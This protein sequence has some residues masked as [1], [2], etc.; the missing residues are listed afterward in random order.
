[1][2]ALSPLRVLALTAHPDNSIARIRLGIPL[3][4]LARQRTIHW[5]MRSVKQ[6]RLRDVLAAQVVIIQREATPVALQWA[7]LARAMGRPLVYEIDD[8]LT[9][10]EP[11]L[12]HHATLLAHV[13]RVL[14]M[15]ALADRISVSTARLQAALPTYVQHK[16]QLTPNYSQPSNVPTTY[17]TE[18]SEA[19]PI[20]LVLASSDAMSLNAVVAGIA[21]WQGRHA[22]P[23]KIV[24][25]G[26]MAKELSDRLAHVEPHHTLSLPA[27]ER[28]MCGLTNPIGL[29]PLDSSPFNACKSAVKFFHY[30]TWGMPVIASNV[31]PYADVILDGCHGLL[32]DANA[33]AWCQAIDHLAS[34]TSRRRTMVAAAQALIAD[35]HSLALTTLAW[36]QLLNDI[37]PDSLPELGWARW[38]WVPRHDWLPALQQ[39]VRRFN[40]RRKHR[41]HQ[42]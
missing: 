34:S 41:R 10:P 25:V 42:A 29:I 21:Q 5:H 22:Y 18:A 2:N 28:L 23:H 26:P 38:H 37:R 20:T 40:D 35:S 16:C 9:A 6:C 32:A 1:M 12:Q 27:F 17:H 36:Q 8:L 31:P 14:S 19:S 24:A 11:H 7:K 15:L 30:G 39:W 4:A 3:D 33:S 13:P